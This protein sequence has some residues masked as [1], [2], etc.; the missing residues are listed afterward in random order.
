MQLLNSNEELLIN[1]PLTEDTGWY[2][3]SLWYQGY[4]TDSYAKEITVDGKI[5]WREGDLFS[6]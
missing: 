4:I 6:V 5:A 2:N 3:C 1:D